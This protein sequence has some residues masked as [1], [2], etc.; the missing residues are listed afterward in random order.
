MFNLHLWR[1]A[2]VKYLL[3]ISV[4]SGCKLSSHH[5]MYVVPVDSNSILT[6]CRRFG[7][8]R[9]FL[10]S[11]SVDTWTCF[12]FHIDWAR[13][14]RSLG[15]LSKSRVTQAALF[16]MVTCNVTITKSICF[17]ILNLIYPVHPWRSTS[18]LI[19]YLGADDLNCHLF[20]FLHRCHHEHTLLTWPRNV[21]EITL[22]S[23]FSLSW[24]RL[25]IGK[26]LIFFFF[27]SEGCG[28]N[29]M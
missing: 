14:S 1:C 19:Y 29:N 13:N 23:H 28:K 9:I 12:S 18:V 17:S 15:H 6:G 22:I 2:I 24:G 11:L 8:S 4:S 7:G 16:K 3:L 26:T 21:R 10:L 27:Y 5:D 20:P 25:K